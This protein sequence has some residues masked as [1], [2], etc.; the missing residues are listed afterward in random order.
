MFLAE[1]NPDDVYLASRAIEQSGLARLEHVASDGREAFDLLQRFETGSTDLILLD[2][3]LPIRN[4][5]EILA[6]ARELPAL[7]AVPVMMLSSSTRKS[8]IREAYRLGASAYLH[9]PSDFEELS[10]LFTSMLAFA[11]NLRERELSCR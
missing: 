2:V 9:K 11:S 10:S 1:D 7:A 4:G 6:K 3:N 5:F 8:D